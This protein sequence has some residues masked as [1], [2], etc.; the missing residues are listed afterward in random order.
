[1][2]NSV[3]ARIVGRAHVAYTC[4][5]VARAIRAYIYTYVRRAGTRCARNEIVVMNHAHFY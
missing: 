2:N 3:R 4:A 1:M 5:S